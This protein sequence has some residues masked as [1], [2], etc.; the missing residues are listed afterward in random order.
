MYHPHEQK[1][2]MRRFHMAVWGSALVTM[3]LPFTTDSYGTTG[4]WCWIES[5]DDA[6]V[7]V[8]TM[9]R[10]LVLYVPLWA[11]EST[12]DPRKTLMPACV[13]GVLRT[14]Y[15]HFCCHGRPYD[16]IVQQ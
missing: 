8:G 3:L 15:R 12:R 11:G 10:Y 6:E 14:S 1:S 2:L 16:L 13:C 4:S 5:T 7:D 9:W